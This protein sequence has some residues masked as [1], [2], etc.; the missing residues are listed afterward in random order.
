MIYQQSKYIS[1]WLAHCFQSDSLTIPYIK[2][3]G[4]D[5]IDID[6][7]KTDAVPAVSN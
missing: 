7:Y 1:N 5:V 4:K 2:E 6:V 3:M